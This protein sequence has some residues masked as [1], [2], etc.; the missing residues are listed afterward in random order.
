MSE[1]FLILVTKK[2]FKKS[3]K[4]IILPI[5]SKT[6]QALREI[7]N[8]AE[9]TVVVS[10]HP[11]N[12]HHQP[13]CMFC[14]QVGRSQYASLMTRM[15]TTF[16]AMDRPDRRPKQHKV[17]LTL[18]KTSISTVHIHRS[19]VTVGAIVGLV[20]KCWYTLL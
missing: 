11:Y 9:K 14:S 15:D 10:G 17:K 7:T 1:E 8:V 20:S 18:I 13:S 19:V 16:S 12:I 2:G 4:H 6:M 5:W 3:M